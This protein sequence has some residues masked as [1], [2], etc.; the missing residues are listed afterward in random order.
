MLGATALNNLGQIAGYGLHD[1]EISTFLLKPTTIDQ[2]IIT[3]QPTSLLT[4]QPFTV[5]V[6]TEA[7]NGNVDTNYNGYV[8]LSLGN[9]TGNATL[10]GTT[11]VQA[12]D[13]IATFDNLDLNRVG[14]Y[15]IVAR[16]TNVAGSPPS[17]PIDVRDQVAIESQPPDSPLNGAPFDL[18]VT[19]KD[20]Y[21][22]EDANYS[23]SVT[24]ALAS[25]TGVAAL[26]GTTTV[27]GSTGETTFADLTLNAVGTYTLAISGD[28]LK[29]LPESDPVDVYDQ[30]V[31]VSQPPDSLDPN[32]TFGI[33]V[34]AI[35]YNGDLDS[36]YNGN[37]TVSIYTHTSTAT[38]DGTTTV[39]AIGGIGSF[40]YLFFT[41]AGTFTLV[42]SGDYLDDSDPSTPVTQSASGI[43]TA[44]PPEVIDVLVDGTDWS[45][46][47][48]RNLQNAYVGNGHGYSIPVG[49][50]A[51]L[52]P[53]PAAVNQILIE[54]DENVNVQKNS[55]MVTGLSVANYAFTNFSY[56]ATTHFATWTLSKP[57][58]ADH[59]LLDLHSTGPQ[60]VTGS[61][62]ASLDGDW[63]DGVSTY[64][65]GDGAAGGDFKFTFNVLPGDANQDGNRECAGHRGCLCRLVTD[66]CSG[67]RR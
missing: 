32:D 60:A 49:S 47:F 15:A 10:V 5:T 58:G 50:S 43:I 25:A 62:G 18:S 24:V 16:G 64:P 19:I 1:G 2:E 48:L 54:F 42:V 9:S 37:V 41:G 28:Y 13:G 35:D 38:L 56:N 39:Q 61:L 63:T 20:Y 29:G 59:V 53:L 4:N 22:H 65:S 30:A 27:Q 8:T 44:R 3:Q 45:G 14:T 40:D 55:L 26:G 51:Q 46:S 21:G 11:T 23:G 6:T 33:A 57:I 66:Q 34:A 36:N 52:N 12:F 7:P 31:I 17:Q 67:I